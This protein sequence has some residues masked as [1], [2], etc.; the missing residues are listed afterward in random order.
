[1]DGGEGYQAT[2]PVTLLI[3]LN[4]ENERR[5]LLGG[6]SQRRRGLCHKTERN[7]SGSVGRIVK[8]GDGGSEGDDGA[9]GRKLGCVESSASPVHLVL[10]QGI[11]LD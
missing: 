3:R 2:T 11:L 9:V 1:M 8:R 6:D 5:W 7:G 10:E 4:A